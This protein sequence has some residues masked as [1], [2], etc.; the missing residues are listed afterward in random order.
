[1][2]DA[3]D[4]EYLRLAKGK[5]SALQKLWGKVIEEDGQI[6]GHGFISDVDGDVWLHHL[7]HH[8]QD[9]H[10]LAALMLAGCSFLKSRGITNFYTDVMPKS[11]TLR[12]YRRLGFEI[13]RI[14]LKGQL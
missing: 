4:E 6:V 2:R 7:H 11:G 14:I 5:S 10:Q 8:G 9:K 3:T 13:D 1:M 12:F